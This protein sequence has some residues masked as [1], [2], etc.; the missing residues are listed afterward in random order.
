MHT[1]TFMNF[2]TLIII[3]IFINLCAG[4][5]PSTFVYKVYIRCFSTQNIK[6]GAYLANRKD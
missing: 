2:D 6:R 4:L 3:F 5:V 1:Y